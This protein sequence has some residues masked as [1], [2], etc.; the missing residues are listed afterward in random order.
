MRRSTSISALAALSLAAALLG[1]CAS[2]IM[3][4]YVG[5]PVT[6][7]MARYGPPDVTFDLPDGRRAFQWIEVSTSTSE[8]QA[9]TRT[10]PDP[11]HGRDATTT[12]TEFTPPTT[13]TSRCHYTMYA[14]YNAAARDWVFDSFEPPAFGC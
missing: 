13:S 11:K 4:G 1:G 3:G 5:Q 8:G 14:R 2:D 10:R 9:T 6:A 12:R 7:A